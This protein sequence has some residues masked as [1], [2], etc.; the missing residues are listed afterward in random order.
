MKSNSSIFSPA[1]LFGTARSMCPK[2]CPTPFS[3]RLGCRCWCGCPVGSRGFPGPR[4]WKK[5]SPWAN[6]DL[7]GILQVIS[8]Y[9]SIIYG[10]LLDIWWYLMYI[11]I[12]IVNPCASHLYIWVNYNDLTVLPHWK[13]WLVRGIIPKWPYFRLV[14]YCNL[15]IYISIIN[16]HKL[17]GGLEHGFYDFPFSWECHNPNWRSPSFFRGIETTNQINMEHSW[18]YYD[19][20]I[21]DIF[22]D[23]NGMSVEFWILREYEWNVHVILVKSLQYSNNGWKVPNLVGWVDR[24][25]LLEAT[26]FRS[27]PFSRSFTLNCQ[28]VI[29]RDGINGVMFRTWDKMTRFRAIGQCNTLVTTGNSSIGYC[30]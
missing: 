18:T 20:L 2:G 15:P 13:S 1:R 22:W 6:S 17:V 11:Y 14:N 24:R 25:G 7:H 10:I 26:F 8:I 28:R 9:R 19:I 29:F 3:R 16:I 12:S 30:I 27:C 4:F 23:M 5:I 21:W